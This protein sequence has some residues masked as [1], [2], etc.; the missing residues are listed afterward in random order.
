LRVRIARGRSYA[1]I[2]IIPRRKTRLCEALHGRRP[3]PDLSS[4]GGSHGELAEGEGEGEWEEGQGDPPG[5]GEGCS[6]VPWGW[7]LGA[8]GCPYV[9]SVVCVLNLRKERRKKK[10]EEKKERK[11]RKKYGKLSKLENFLK[12]KDNL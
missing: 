1:S 8:A 10:G 11:K 6:G 3:W 9:L 2:L 4:M 12:I 7:L 5:E